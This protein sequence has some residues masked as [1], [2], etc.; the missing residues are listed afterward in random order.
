MT[1]N[2]NDNIPSCA[3]QNTQI[4]LWLMAGHTITSLEA[5]NMFGCMRLASR[6]FDLREQGLDIGVRKKIT[7]SGKYVA[8]YWLKNAE[9]QS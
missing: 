9:P 8:E 4:R 3:S 2:D 5:L 6:V 1:K 7:A